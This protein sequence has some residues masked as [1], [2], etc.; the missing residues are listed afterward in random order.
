MSSVVA[1]LGFDLIWF[2]IIV[3]VAIENSLITPVGLNVFVLRS[4]MPD[5][6]TRT[7]FARHHR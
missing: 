6:S 5:I 1:C 7:I 2:G 3:V 4:V